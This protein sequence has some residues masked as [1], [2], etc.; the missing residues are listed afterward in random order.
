MG[1]CLCVRGRERWESVVMVCVLVGVGV[2]YKGLWYPVCWGGGG[3]G[4]GGGGRGGGL[5]CIW[6][7]YIDG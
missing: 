3:G 4:G 2:C 5:V 1:I 7:E 6:R